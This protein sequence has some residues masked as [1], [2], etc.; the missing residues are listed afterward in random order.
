MKLLRQG[1]LLFV[2]TCL[3][4]SLSAGA[5]E[6]VES[7]IESSKT[8]YYET[9]FPGPLFQ[10]LSSATVYE[11]SLAIQLH[12][13]TI[14]VEATALFAQEGDAIISFKSAEEYLASDCFIESLHPSF[15]LQS[16]IELSETKN[17]MSCHTSY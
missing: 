5:L 14:A 13:G 16:D 12:D 3:M 8:K 11:G 15:L 4:T 17:L 1:F 7:A 10:K 9:A 2:L 6:V